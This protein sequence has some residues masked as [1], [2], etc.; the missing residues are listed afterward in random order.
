[1]RKTV[2]QRI[3]LF[4]VSA[5]IQA[6]LYSQINID[7]LTL[8]ATSLPDDSAK[9]TLLQKISWAIK[10]ENPGEAI[11]YANRALDLSRLKNYPNLEAKSLKHIATAYLLAGNYRKA[12]NYYLTAIEIFDKVNNLRGK[13]DCYNNLGL[14][15]QYKGNNVDASEAYKE[16][17]KL[18]KAI[19]NKSG[20]AASLSNLG[21]VLQ[22][23]GSY[24]EAL[25]RY[26]ESL[27]IRYEI[28][29][30]KGIATIYN[31]IGAIYE[32]QKNYKKALKNYQEALTKYTETNNTRLACLAMNNIGYVLYLQKEYEKALYYFKQTIEKRIEI[33]DKKGLSITTLNMANLYLDINEYNTALKYLNMSEK[34]CSIIGNKYEINQV[35]LAKSKYY[36]KQKNYAEVIKLLGN[37][38]YKNDL[39]TENKTELFDMLGQ[40]FFA[41]GNYKKAFLSQE[42]YIKIKDSINQEA[43]TKKIIQIQT[44]YEFEKKS[45]ELMLRKEKQA[46]IYKQ[47]MMQQKLINSIVL[48]I[49]IAFIL[50]SIFIYRSYVLK[51]RDNKLLY[52]HKNQNEIINKEL[53]KYR[54]KLL[55]DNQR[56]E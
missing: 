45:N 23:N 41:M 7:S 55:Q 53:I 19:N 42:N 15:L 47:E 34:Y 38:D 33:D 51:K 9:I 14:T 46:L 6:H 43:N 20:E 29:D 17:I 32:K 28:N 54:N 26:M 35:V 44:E 39:L 24:N 5:F 31:N 50:L 12:E 18:D 52:F 11:K 22:Q 48:T 25:G 40:A 36:L 3:F 4:F 49:L 27:K 1:M 10:S 2:L 56:L 21:N 30:L 13:S 37:I 16:S 8:L